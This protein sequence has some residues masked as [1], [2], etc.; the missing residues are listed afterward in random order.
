MANAPKP[1]IIGGMFGLGE[2]L[3]CRNSQVQNNQL[4]SLTVFPNLSAEA[5]P[6]GFP[7]RLKNRDQVR[8]RLFEHNI[9]PPV[10]WQIQ[11]ATP[12]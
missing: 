7:I 6:S 9:C 2:E 4:G 5:V 12:E 11:G 10:H 8:Q 1:Q 3:R